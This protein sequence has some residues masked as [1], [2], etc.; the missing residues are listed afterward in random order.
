MKSGE[1]LSVRKNWSNYTKQYQHTAAPQ[2]D[3]VIQKLLNM[4]IAMF[5]IQKQITA[6]RIRLD[7]TMFRYRNPSSRAKSLS[8]LTAVKVSRETSNSTTPKRKL[9]P[10]MGP[11]NSF[12]SFTLAIK[13]IDTMGCSIALTHMSVTARQRNKI[14]DGGCM[15]DSFRSAIKIRIFPM[16]AMIDKTMQGISR[17]ACVPPR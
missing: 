14:F 1:D 5:R 15:G 9:I 13:R 6:A 2:E 17:L 12:A 7:V 4:P 8:T 11:Q 10:E 3:K 16:E